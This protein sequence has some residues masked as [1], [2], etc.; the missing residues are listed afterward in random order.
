MPQLPSQAMNSPRAE[1]LHTPSVTHDSHNIQSHER[2]TMDIYSIFS[3]CI[4]G[5]RTQRISTDRELPRSHDDGQVH[6]SI[7]AA[8]SMCLGSF[9]DHTAR[10]HPP[11][12]LQVGVP[13]NTDRALKF[14]LRLKMERLWSPEVLFQTDLR[15][16]W[17]KKM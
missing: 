11:T 16:I 9:K 1:L 2:C 12:T 4:W 8:D 5:A 13:G 14:L 17:G 3:P 10:G 6:H 15:V 7:T